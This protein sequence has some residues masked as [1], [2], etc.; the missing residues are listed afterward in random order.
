MASGK[1]SAL[2]VGLF[3][4]VALI[5]G[6]AWVGGRHEPRIRQTVTGGDEPGPGGSG[7]LSIEG[8]T[9]TDSL[10]NASQVEA[11][12]VAT[13][14][15]DEFPGIYSCSFV[16]RD[17]NGREVGRYEDIVASLSAPHSFPVK[18]EASSP[19]T[20][21]DGRCGDRLDT[22]TPYR[23]DLTNVHV[24]SGHE[25]PGVPGNGT[26]TVGFDA[27]WVGGGQA[28]AVT[29]HVAV[30]NEAGAVIGSNDFNLFI[31]MGSGADLTAG[32]DVSGAPA[33]AELDCSPFAG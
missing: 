18:V 30:L 22:G 2:A 29:C 13:W 4:A 16:A 24:T 25:L 32:V 3:L 1:R 20:S 28:G 19:A 11:Q 8:I 17:Q 6:L 23:Y 33:N 7:V 26:A 9:V 21:M 5:A 14:S 27:N 10:N 15:G 12:A 31:L